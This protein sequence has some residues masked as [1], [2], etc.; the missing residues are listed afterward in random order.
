MNEV[1]YFVLCSVFCSMSFKWTVLFWV[2][3]STAH[4]SALS[5]ALSTVF[6]TSLLFSFPCWVPTL[7]AFSTYCMRSILF[8]YSSQYSIYSGRLHSVQTPQWKVT[9]CA[10]PTVEGYILCRA[11]SGRLHSEQSPQWKVTFCAEPT[12]EGYI[13]CRAHSGRLNFVH[14]PQWKS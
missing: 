3:C 13:L 5:R 9:F 4:C 11:H 2:H 1:L 6:H 14:S 12:V 7:A 10:E 8:S